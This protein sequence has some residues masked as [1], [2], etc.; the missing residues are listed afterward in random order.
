MDNLIITNTE[1]SINSDNTVSF[2]KTL[3]S[4]CKF[5]PS[6]IKALEIFFQYAGS[7]VNTF[8]FKRL[9]INS[10]YA[11]IRRL[12]DKGVNITSALSVA[13]DSAGITHKGIAHY[14]LK[15]L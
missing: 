8:T 11:C 4:T 12:K 13:I 10:V 5:Q 1:I 14:T 15:G 6:E 9:G 7:P 3:T 2:I